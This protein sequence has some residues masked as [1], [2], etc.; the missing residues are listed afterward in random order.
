MN[1]I[2][3]TI[4]K[5]KFPT[6][7]VPPGTSII[8]KNSDATSHSAETLKKAK[9]YFNA[10]AIRPGQSS[11]PIEFNSIGEYPYL[12][13]Y[14]HGMTG[15]VVVHNGPIEIGAPGHGH[16][17]HF[18]HLHGFVTN[19]NDTD[20]LYLTH[21]PILA[22]TRHHFQIVLRARIVAQDVAKIYKNLR[23]SPFG[24]GRVDVY[25]SHVSLLDIRDGKI[26]T[27]PKASL[28]YF[29]NGSYSLI[30]GID[31]KEFELEIMEVLHFH[32]FDKD[33][34]YPASLE[35]LMYGSDTEVFIDHFMNSAPSFHSVAKLK[36]IPK[37]WKG[38]GTQR[39]TIPSKKMV[40]SSPITLDRVAFVDNAF[41][42]A[43]LP[44]PGFLR[45]EPQDPLKARDGSSTEY[46]CVSSEGIKG[47]LEVG[48][49]I[50]FD[51]KLLN[52]GVLIV[53]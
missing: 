38:T 9:D 16:G 39:L 50:H 21:T 52:Y 49:H 33:M 19:G 4:A 2:I 30:P 47:T 25:H 11:L 3:V 32:T 8:W 26:T 41:S 37:F 34:D 40:S 42:L 48:A 51:Y 28:A 27:L 53:D 23:E 20:S 22:D 15:K 1:T 10:G 43:W 7:K 24:D 31:E 29:P 44:P 36:T 45:P 35:Y 5:N 18:K 13:R 14:H 17:H 12:C 6:I 46:E